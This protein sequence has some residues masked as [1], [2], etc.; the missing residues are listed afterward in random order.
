M[1][2]AGPGSIVRMAWMGRGTGCCAVARWSCRQDQMRCEVSYEAISTSNRNS[3][4]W[5]PDLQAAAQWPLIE[6]FFS[7]FPS[8]GLLFFLWSPT[9]VFRDAIAVRCDAMG[10]RRR[11]SC[12]CC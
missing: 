5:I 1:S 9:P 7:P 12:R 3:A 11:H 2:G 8:R 6:L 10:E 4:A